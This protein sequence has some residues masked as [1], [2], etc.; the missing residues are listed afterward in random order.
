M[1]T[2]HGIYLAE[3]RIVLQ[4]PSSIIFLWDS[5]TFLAY[6]NVKF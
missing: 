6:N 1:L 4:T 2:L 5:K 3:L